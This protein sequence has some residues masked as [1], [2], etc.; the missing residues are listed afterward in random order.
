MKNKRFFY[1]I[2][3][4]IG[5]VLLNVISGINV[6]ASDLKI[7]FQDVR[8]DFWAKPA[9]DNWKD[10]GVIKGDGVNFNPNNNIT[11][12]EMI[13]ILNK[14]FGFNKTISNP[15]TDLK[16]DEWYYDAV[17]R[18][19]AHG[20]IKGSPDENGN[21]MARSN[22]PLTRAEAAVIFKNVFSI[23][24]PLNFKT[25]FKDDKLPRWAEDAIFA[26]ESSGYI[27]GKGDGLFEPN[28]NL[29]RAEMV[30]LLDNIIDLFI[31]A[32]G[33]YTENI[34]GNV[35]V[36]TSGATLKNMRITGNLYLAE[37][38]GEG[39]VFLKDVYIS[40]TTF[41]RGG[42]KYDIKVMDSDLGEVN[43]EKEDVVLVYVE[44]P[45]EKGENEIPA[46]ETDSTASDVPP[47]GGT[48]DPA[49]SDS[50]PSHTGPGDSS[51]GEPSEDK[52]P[53]SDN[54]DKPDTGNPD[55]DDEERAD[56]VDY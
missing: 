31:N 45:V 12:A 26:M 43:I 17:I 49:P 51:S 28:S 4:T 42:G 1:Y 27:R 52:Q 30:Q 21:P 25:S 55:T 54:T 20:I 29:T 19:Y 38:I 3:F 47:S 6:L 50:P 24:M 40:G 15:F 37:G 44:E 16:G 23:V 46:T 41:I 48:S 5:V 18:A 35:V 13:V 22:D 7:E 2:V 9:I 39:E 34:D 32:P 14:I 10:K 11:R 56:I 33:E 8:E 53:D 36:N